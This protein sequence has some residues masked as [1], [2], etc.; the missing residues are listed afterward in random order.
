MRTREWSFHYPPCLAR[1]RKE[2]EGK[3][4]KQYK[5][6]HEVAVADDVLAFFIPRARVSCILQGSVSRV[7]ITNTHA[8]QSGGERIHVISEVRFRLHA[9]LLC[10]RRPGPPFGVSFPM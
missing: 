3:L 5:L 2:E 10:G 8:H 7:T 1:A 9:T 4:A 6:T